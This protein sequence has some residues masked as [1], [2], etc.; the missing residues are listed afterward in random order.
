MIAI[1]VDAHKRVHAALALDDAGTVLGSWR[2]SNTAQG[3]LELWH[4]ASQW[5]QPRH[6]GIEG[7][8]NYGRGLAQ[9]LVTHQEVVYDINPRWTAERRRR[10]RKLDKNDRLDAHAVARLVREDGPTL[11]RVT[12]EDESVVLDL[13]VSE[14]EAVLAETIRLRNQLHQ[15]LLQLAP[16]Y[17]ISL[18]NLRS[19]AG[20]RAVEAFLPEPSD[21][22]QSQR[23]EG[24]RRLL[25][26]L[27]LAVEQTKVLAKKIRALATQ[28]FLP[29]TELCGVQLLTAGML[30]GI[31]GPGRRFTSEAQLAAYAGVAPI[32]ASSAGTIRHRLNRGGNRRQ[33]AI[34][35]P[36]ALVQATSSPQAKAYL[37]RRQTE[38]KTRREAIRA[39]KRHLIRAIWRL[40]QRCLIGQM[41]P[42]PA[43]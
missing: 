3:W 31:L 43:T 23:T 18:P 4:W 37:A 1:G 22:L 38:G 20:L 34:L 36:I 12:G 8:W 28:H 42:V 39:L 14:R 7:A 15:L 41:E 9:F 32:E 27:Q 29:L 17:A 16:D 2:G 33:G 26:R 30:A 24:I 5:S 6:W 21:F 11:P 40:W 19:A 35:Y 25:E 10:T 13:L